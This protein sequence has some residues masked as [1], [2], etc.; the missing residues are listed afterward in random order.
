MSHLPTPALLLVFVLAAAAVCRAGVVLTRATDALDDAL[1]W[2][3]EMGGLV[4]LA[5][6]TN[7]PEVAITVSA[8][9]AGRVEVAVANLL[10]GIAIQTLLLALFDAWGNRGQVPLSTRVAS[11]AMQLEGGLVVLMLGLVF[12]GHQ[13]PAG[14][15][16]GGVTPDGLLMLLAWIGGLL[17]IRRLSRT[18]GPAAAPPRARKGAQPAM[19]LRRAV[20]GFVLMAAVTLAGGVL[21]EISGDALAARWGMD[22]ALFG[23]TVLA[24]ATA[25]PEVATGLPAAR[26]G[27]HALAVSDILGG[28]AVLPVLLVLATALAGQPVLPQAGA[29]TLYMTGLGLVMTLVFLSGMARRAPR[30]HAGMGWDSWLLLAGYA[31]GVAGL[32]AVPA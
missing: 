11:P 8:A 4:L 18:R 5:I 26:Q 21:L 20:V 16:L 6:V 31:A 12:L 19:G 22:G 30:K 10:G 9:L 23:A 27:E 7:L 15:I 13:M 2:G 28:N 24:A 14:A 29:Q 25:L 3:Q 32:L 17:A 1:G